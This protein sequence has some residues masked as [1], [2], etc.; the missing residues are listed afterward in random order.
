M[1]ALQ[2]TQAWITFGGIVKQVVVAAPLTLPR[3]LAASDGESKVGVSN[4]KLP[5][6]RW[7][8]SKV[9]CSDNVEHVLN[10]GVWAATGAK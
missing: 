2:D 9:Q 4:D 7:L 8:I 1:W 10:K 3:P 5:S 6:P